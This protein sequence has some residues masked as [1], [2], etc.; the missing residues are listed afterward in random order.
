MFMATNDTSKMS[1]I[2][3]AILSRVLIRRG[4][5]ARALL[6]SFSFTTSDKDGRHSADPVWPATERATKGKRN[7]TRE[8]GLRKRD[9]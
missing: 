6:I 8:V 9:S 5:I 4:Y 1:L 2:S 3:S 7:I